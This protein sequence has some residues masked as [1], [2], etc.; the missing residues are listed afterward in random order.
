MS[1]RLDKLASKVT[2]TG[3]VADVRQ[4]TDARSW[5]LLQVE[6]IDVKGETFPLV[7]FL[8]VRLY[9]GE[10]T[11]QLL[12]G[13]VIQCQS[14]LRKPRLFGTPGEF[15][16]PRYLASQHTAMTGWVKNFD[17]IT[18]LERQDKFP[19][20]I[21]AQWRTTLATAITAMMPEDR[22]FMVRALVLGEGRVIPTHIRKTLAQSGIS[23]LFAISGLHFGM[24]GL[25]CY[26]LLLP[27][28]CRFPRLLNWQ[29][30]QRVLPLLLLPL[31]LGYLLLTWRCSLY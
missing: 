28:Y 18:I 30:P 6:S 10:G 15:N 31:L 24:I 27:L 22:A 8:P 29:P 17:K 14:R 16:W 21:A 4:L 3:L 13:D 23:H 1:F 2:I 9:L 11:D 7:V 19:V 26:R 12:P 20:R 25:L 5:L